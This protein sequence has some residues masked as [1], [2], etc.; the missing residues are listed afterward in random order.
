M[1]ITEPDEVNSA[2]GRCRYASHAHRSPAIRSF[3]PF[4]SCYKA[5]KEQGL[6]PS[7]TVSETKHN[8]EFGLQTCPQCQRSFNKQEHLDRHARSHS[9]EKPYSCPTCDKRFS[10]IDVMQ[11]H[12]RLHETEAEEPSAE[13]ANRINGNT[14]V[15]SNGNGSSSVSATQNAAS[16]PPTNGYAGNGNSGPTAHVRSTSHHSVAALSEGSQDSTALPVSAMLPDEAVYGYHMMRPHHDQDHLHPNGHMHLY[17]SKF[18]PEPLYNQQ[19]SQ[20]QSTQAQQ[21]PQHMYNGAGSIYEQPSV[22]SEYDALR[23][24]FAAESAVPIWPHMPANTGNVHHAPQPNFG[25]NGDLLADPHQ[26]QDDA[27]DAAVTGTAQSRPLPHRSRQHL[28]HI[29]RSFPFSGFMHQTVYSQRLTNEQVVFAT[30]Q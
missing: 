21:P 24:F 5:A 4:P 8:A 9:G 18:G 27:W 2:A 29:Q 7:S 20:Q 16:A 12:Q 15:Q 19:R 23:P 17:Q 3:A 30:A 28:E 14:L 26:Y 10:R 25:F 1:V 11:R 22:S 13:L 6:L